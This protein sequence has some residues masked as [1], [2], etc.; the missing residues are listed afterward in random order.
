MELT[1]SD[2]PFKDHESY[3]RIPSRFEVTCRLVAPD[4]Q[5]AVPVDAPWVKDYDHLET[6]KEWP[7]RFDVTHWRLFN[8]SVNGRPAGGAILAFRCPEF[9]LLDGRDDLVHVVDLRVAP[10]FQRIGVGR[11][12]WV[13]TEAWA[14]CNGATEI[15]V[16]TQDVNVAAC[17]FYAA[18]GCRVH[19]ANLRAYGEVDEV[20]LIWSKSLI[21]D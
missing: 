16:E 10:A 19:S 12:L 14:A 18:V 11:S 1:V 5:A 17:Q 7:S 13:A 4:F 2:Q 15:R 3:M 20:Q 8:A 9:N 6:P 21:A